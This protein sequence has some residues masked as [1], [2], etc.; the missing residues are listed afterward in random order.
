MDAA[1][2][3]HRNASARVSPVRLVFRFA[4]AALNLRHFGWLAPI[5]VG[6]TL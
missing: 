2:R 1:S 4:L 3:V 5:G 6:E